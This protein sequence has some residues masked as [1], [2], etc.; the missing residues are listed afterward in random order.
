MTDMSSGAVCIGSANLLAK[1]EGQHLL[2]ATAQRSTKVGMRFDA[3]DDHD[4]IR[5]KRGNAEDNIPPAQSRTDLLHVHVGING[6]TEAFRRNPVLGQYFCLA[7]RRGSTMTAHRRYHKRPRARSDQHAEC[8]LHNLFEICD[9]AAANAHGNPHSGRY[10]AAQ[11]L[12]VELL[13]KE[14]VEVESRR[15]RISLRDLDQIWQWDTHRDSARLL[16]ISYSTCGA[17]QVCC[18]FF[19]TAGENSARFRIAGHLPGVLF[20]VCA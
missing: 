13:G 12:F 5:S 16:Y 6:N 4:S 9:T 2:N 19:Q 11:A 17:V 18:L 1:T 7:L 15:S 20:G 8:S 3:I 14:S 10:L